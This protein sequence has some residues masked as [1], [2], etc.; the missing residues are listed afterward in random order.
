VEPTRPKA[1]ALFAGAGGMSQG[2]LDAG[3]D[4]L[5]AT[6]LDKHACDTYTAN[7]PDIPFLV[8]DAKNKKELSSEIVLEKIGFEKGQLD[9]VFGGPPCRGFSNGNRKNGGPQNEYNAL[10]EEY[11][12]LVAE[13]E[14]HW[15]VLENVIGLYYMDEIRGKFEGLLSNYQISARIINAADYGVP[16]IRHRAIFVGNR[17]GKEFEF[18]EGKFAPRKNSKRSKERYISVWEAISD[19]PRLGKTTGQDETPY[20]NGPKTP[21]QELIRAGSEKVFNHTITKSGPGVLERY[22]L[23][24]HGENWSSLP[25]EMILRWRKTPIEKVKAY[26]HSNLYLRLNPGEPSVT[27][28]NFRKSMFIHPFEDR[29]LSLREAAR[30]Q[31]FPDR[32]T[33]KGGIS[34]DQQHIGN[35]TPPLLARAVAEQLLKCMKSIEIENAAA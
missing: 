23:I 8:A 30:L 14:P 31:S 17:D 20:T 32:Y 19:L 1:V 15:F 11:A 34:H 2:F 28:G 18:P 7:H 21:Y 33:F 9:V 10:V 3:F 12:R 25:D 35:A 5:L 16:Q 24:G 29:G 22:A 13:L 6:D 27:V 4:V 26:S